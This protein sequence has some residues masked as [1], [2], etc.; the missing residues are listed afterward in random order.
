MHDGLLLE[1][2]GERLSI[3]PLSNIRKLLRFLGIGEE[4]FAVEVI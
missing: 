2:N 1:I 4:R 3:P